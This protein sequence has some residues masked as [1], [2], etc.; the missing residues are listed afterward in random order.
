MIDISQKSPFYLH[1]H[2]R[3]CKSCSDRVAR[4]FICF[5]RVFRQRRLDSCWRFNAKD[6]EGRFCQNWC[7]FLQEIKS[8]HFRGDQK[9][10][11]QIV[12]PP[13]WWAALT[14][15]NSWQNFPICMVRNKAQMKSSWLCPGGG[16]GGWGEFRNFLVGICR[17]D[18]DPLASYQS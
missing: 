1:V 9:L 7:F 15:G 6:Y 8:L 3:T 12:N 17:L 2:N 18:L 5:L 11:K 10:A 14:H 16:G 13:K 4:I